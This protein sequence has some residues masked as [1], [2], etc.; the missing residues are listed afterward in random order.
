MSNYRAGC[1]VQVPISLDVLMKIVNDVMYERASVKQAEP[2][3]IAPPR[4][5]SS[6]VKT[7]ISAF[8][9]E[10]TG[11]YCTREIIKHHPGLNPDSIKSVL[12]TMRNQGEIDREQNGKWY[13]RQA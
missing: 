3:I 8:V 1:T 5:R 13:L 10:N 2:A 9:K 12:N 6:A 11:R 4:M 7:P